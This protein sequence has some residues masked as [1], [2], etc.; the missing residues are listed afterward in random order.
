MKKFFLFG[1]SFVVIF[2]VFQM[3][4][5]MVLTWMHTPNVSEAW[6]MSGSL[7]QETV[8]VG[9]FSLVSLG[10]ILASAMIAYIISNRIMQFN[11]NKAELPS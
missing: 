2:A 7:P 8:I 1:V 9:N 10:M 5:G 6:S 4:S 11:K 3:L